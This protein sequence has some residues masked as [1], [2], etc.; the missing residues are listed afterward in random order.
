MK[1][2]GA[3]QRNCLKE[4]ILLQLLV[5]YNL[6]LTV[7]N[8]CPQVKIIEVTLFATV[9]GTPACCIPLICYVSFMSRP[10]QKSP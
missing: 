10:S 4:L 1:Y 9:S 3:N 5:E 6:Y 8:Q 2:F 7:C